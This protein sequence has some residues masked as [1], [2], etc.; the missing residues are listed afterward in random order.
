[1]GKYSPELEARP[2]IT[3]HRQLWPEVIVACLLERILGPEW[4]IEVGSAP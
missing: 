1:M 3:G 2:S 4:M